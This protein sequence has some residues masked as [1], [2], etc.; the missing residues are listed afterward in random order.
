MADLDSQIG[1][2]KCCRCS[3]EIIGLTRIRLGPLLSIRVQSS[4]LRF[5][6]RNQDRDAVMRPLIR[7]ATSQTSKMPNSF[8]IS[9]H[10][11]HML[12]DQS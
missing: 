12:Y 8:V 10:F 4:P 1:R 2:R 7:E 5:E 6:I 9:Q 11:A 3:G